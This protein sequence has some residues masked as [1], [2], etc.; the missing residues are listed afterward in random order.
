MR[1]LLDVLGQNASAR[2]RLRGDDHRGHNERSGNDPDFFLPILWD[3]HRTGGRPMAAWFPSGARAGSRGKFLSA[4]GKHQLQTSTLENHAPCAGDRNLNATT[5]P[6]CT[7]VHAG[8]MTVCLVTNMEKKKMVEHIVAVFDG[9]GPASAAE[10]ELEQAGIPASAIRRYTTNEEGSRPGYSADTSAAAGNPTTDRPSG[11]GFWAWLLGEE[12]PRTSYASQHTGDPDV[13]DRSIAAGRTVLSVTLTDDSHIHRAMDIIEA[14][15]PLD[16]DERADES[17]MAGTGMAGVSGT[18]STAGRTMGTGMGTAG[19][20]Y[21]SGATARAGEA[22]SPMPGSTPAGTTPVGT[23]PVGATPVG[24]TPAARS[25]ATART[26]PDTG[27]AKGDEVIPLAEEQLDIGKRVVDRGTTRIRRY[28]TETPVER[29][30]D[31]HG[32][33]VT[34]ERRKPV[35]TAGAPGA[36]AFEERTVEVRETEEVPVTEKTARV[37]EEVV[38]HREGTER[39]E[40]VRDT[41]RREEADITKDGKRNPANRK[42]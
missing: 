1:L 21:S 26:G 16:I 20:D 13:Y 37:V 6:R 3:D 39:T 18:P 35:D 22:A 14:H 38:V 12:G 23:T 28:V 19:T 29:S 5:R 7:F 36:G 42:P 34:I 11:G 27:T 10:R 24:A 2:H 8:E 32:E 40:T 31:L 41:V 33:R 15:D 17:G 25:A 9:D 4:C 30:V